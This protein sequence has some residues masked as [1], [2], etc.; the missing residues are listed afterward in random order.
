MILGILLSG[1]SRTETLV[2]VGKLF[3]LK[4]AICCLFYHDEAGLIFN[5]F[6]FYLH[7]VHRMM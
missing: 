7:I 4:F 6:L 5:F 1:H 2:E 3:V